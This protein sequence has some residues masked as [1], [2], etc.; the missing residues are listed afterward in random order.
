MGCIPAASTAAGLSAK[1]ADQLILTLMISKSLLVHSF[2]SRLFAE[3]AA[4]SREA[5][6]FGID[7]G[8]REIKHFC[9]VFYIVMKK[10]MYRFV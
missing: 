7:L 2:M 9:C 6:I 3:S 10:D 5:R 4:L 8:G 1:S